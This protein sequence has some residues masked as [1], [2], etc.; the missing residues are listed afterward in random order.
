MA[1]KSKGGAMSQST[2][3]RVL[4]MDGIL[5]STVTG[6]ENA[7]QLYDW[8]ASSS[9]AAST[10]TVNSLVSPASVAASDVT[11]VIPAGEYVT[12]IKTNMVKAVPFKKISVIRL[13]NVQSTNVEMEKTEYENCF[14]TS[15][16]N[17]D[18]KDNGSNLPC[19]EIKFRFSKETYTVIAYNQDGTKK[20]QTVMN[21]DYVKATQV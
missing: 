14:I 21:F 2:P 19:I 6:F 7:S 3:D 13:G 17:V 15:F 5:S 11:V 1:S 10:S 12:S 9:R 20:G 16:Q 8:K 18:L 4:K